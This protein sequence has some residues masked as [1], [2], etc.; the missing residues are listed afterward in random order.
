MKKNMTVASDRLGN[1]K[2]GKILVALAVP[3]MISMLIQALYNIVDSMFVAQLSQDAL[4]AVSISFPIQN[5]MIAVGTGIG[6]G[7]N[8]QISKYLGRKDQESAQ[9]VV[10]HGLILV[11]MS[12]LL[13]VLIGQFGIG[14]FLKFQNL[15]DHINAQASSYLKI[16]SMLSFGL[17]GQLIFERLLQSTGKTILSMIS[18]GAGAIINVVLDPI[19]IFGLFGV[20]K[21]GVAGAA[22]ATIIGQSI[23]FIIGLQLHRYYNTEIPIRFKG[24]TFE[25]R[26]IRRILSIGIPTILMI[27]ISSFMNFGINKIL[28]NLTSTATAVFGAYFKLQSFVFMPVFGLNN[29]LIPLISYNIGARKKIRV[30]NFIKLGLISATTIMVLGLALMQFFPVALLTLFN[31]SDDMMTI[32]IPALKIISIGFVMAG[33]SIII[34]SVLQVAGRG[35][36]SASITAFRQLIILL[37]LAYLLSLTG[38][39]ELVWWAFPVSE[40]LAI[41][42]SFAMLKTTIKIKF[43]F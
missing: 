25:M 34:G 39:V 38:R 23:A 2:E 7:T 14:A 13:F 16:V 9:K 40:A 24:F 10:V 6:V 22:I 4:T 26:F 19:L 21:M 1:E 29:A 31:A 32:G 35:F 18:Q 12:F 15:N 42:F 27:S 20:P 5:L 8:A 3:L 41:I 43:R 17:F 37:P 28:T 11:F 36:L 30:K 33:A